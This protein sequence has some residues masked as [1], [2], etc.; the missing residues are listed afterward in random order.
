[1]WP[2]SLVLLASLPTTPQD[3]WTHSWSRSSG[4]LAVDPLRARLAVSDSGRAAAVYSGRDG[5]WVFDPRDP[6][7]RRRLDVAGEAIEH[8]AFQGD[9]SLAA[10][11]GETLLF[12]DLSTDEV[13]RT[14]RLP[15]RKFAFGS[16]MLLIEAASSAPHSAG[17]VLQLLP[18]ARRGTFRRFEGGPGRLNALVW[19][20]TGATF[21][22]AGMYEQLLIGNR[23]R[24]LDLVRPTDQVPCYSVCFDPT[25]T[26]VL[27]GFGGARG[28]IVADIMPD[29]DRTLLDQNVPRPVTQWR[30]I[31]VGDE[32]VMVRELGFVGKRRFWAGIDGGVL[33]VSWPE[34]DERTY[35][36]PAGNV[37]EESF[38]VE[39]AGSA[40]GETLVGLTR[41]GA[42]YVGRMRPAISRGPVEARRPQRRFQNR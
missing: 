9:E 36:T 6:G 17:Y 18:L 5:L 37:D 31:P 28:I 35:Q 27:A 39:W 40:G 16:N 22:S 38:F 34:A 41:N 24:T 33:L 10:S 42:L 7:K 15:V 32:A 14:L 23:S 2:I 1:M 3:E 25:G 29:P 8:I 12:I 21:A 19:D 13:S 26:K 30:S 20:S 4:Q 11:T